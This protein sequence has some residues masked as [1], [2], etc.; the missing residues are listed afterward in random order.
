METVPYIYIYVTCDAFV[1]N[2]AYAFIRSDNNTTKTHTV[3]MP[4]DY[5]SAKFD[6]DWNNERKAILT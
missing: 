3:R 6:S 4:V 2:C 1:L 5:I